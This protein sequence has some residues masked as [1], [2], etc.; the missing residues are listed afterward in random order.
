MKLPIEYKITPEDSSCES[1]RTFHEIRLNCIE[2]CIYKWLMERKI[3]HYNCVNR[4]LQ[5][6]LFA[7]IKG[8]I[9]RHVAKLGNHSP[10][11]I[12]WDFYE[13]YDEDFEPF[14]CILSHETERLFRES[15]QRLAEESFDDIDKMIEN[16][17]GDDSV[18][19]W[20]TIIDMENPHEALKAIAKKIDI[21]NL[22]IQEMEDRITQY[23]NLHN[24]DLEDMAFY[25]NGGRV[26]DPDDILTQEHEAQ[27]AAEKRR[28]VI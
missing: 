9:K 7:V 26:L 20:I 11:S 19:D 18:M 22:S 28:W 12:E 15:A 23:L 10:N 16:S 24:I 4:L 25:P 5:R 2:S 14:I 17:Q 21:E 1:A 13:E 27:Q 8:K 6:H 3:V